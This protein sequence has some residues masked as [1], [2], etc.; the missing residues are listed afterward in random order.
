MGPVNALQPLR[1][2]L[3][4][5]TLPMFAATL[6]APPAPAQPADFDFGDGRH[7]SFTV[8]AGETTI[9]DLWAQV[10]TAS[11]LLAYDPEHGDQVPQL[12]NLTISSGGT[13]TV[14]PYTGNASGA[15]DPTQGGVLRLKV[16]GTL[17]IQ[18]GGA[19]SATGRGYR[20]GTLEGGSPGFIGQQGDSWGN[21]GAI[22][23]AANRG[24]GGGGFGEINGNAN[25][26]SGGGGGH[27]EAGA[28][29]A[30]GQGTQTGGLGGEAFDTVA[31]AAGQGFRDTYLFP[32]FGSGGGRGGQTSNFA[33]IGAYGG[34]GGGVIII[35]AERIVNNGTISADG[36]VGGSDLSGGGGGAGGSILIQTLSESNGTVTVAG[37]AGGVGTV[38]GNVG[39][40]GASGI[41]LW[42]G[43][44]AL[45]TEVVGEGVI[46]LTPAGGRYDDNTV[47]SAEAI[48]DE[49]WMFAGWSGDLSGTDNPD[50]VTMTGDRSI[51]AT[52]VELP[53]LT[54]EPEQRDVSPFGGDL[55][56]GV[57]VAGGTEDIHWTTTVTDGAEFLSIASGA[58]GTND[59]TITVTA[60]P[61]AQENPR[62]G[63][64]LVSSEDVGSD[65]VVITITQGPSTPMLSVTPAEQ[66]ALAEGEELVI[67]VLNTGTG[68]FDWTAAIL[69]GHS[70]A[71]I[72]SAATGTNDGTFVV[73]VAPNL[74]PLQRTIRISVSAPG[75]FGSPEEVTITQLAGVPLLQVSPTSQLIG[76]AAGTASLNVSNGGSGSLGWTAAVIEGA[77]FATITSGSSG[78]N[79]G[80]VTVAFLGN[81][82][83]S[84]RTAKIRVE[85][86]DAANSP[87]DVTIIQTAQEAVLQ[88]SPE[89]QSIGSSAGSASFQVL[90]AGSGT[91]NWTAAV[92][93]GANF[94]SISTGISGTNEGAV[95]VAATA[96]TTGQE[97]SA[98]IRISAPGAANSPTD[99]TLTQAASAPVLR[100]APTEQSV[101]AGGGNISITVE[102]G[103]TGTLNWTASVATGA[104]F[105]SLTPPSN[106]VE[107][108]V[109]QVAVAA[110]ISG[111]SRTGTIR[112]EGTGATSSPQTAT[113]IQLGC[114][115]LDPPANLAASDGTSPDGVDLIWSAVPGA[116]GYEIFR[117]P[118]SDRDHFELLATTTEPR[119]TDTA[120]E[121]PTYELIRE[122]CFNPGEFDIDYT[123]YYYEVRAVNPCGASTSSNRTTGYRGLPRD[124][125]DDGGTD[126]GEGEGEDPT[127]TA[128]KALTEET[129]VGQASRVALLLANDG[130]ID[131]STIVLNVNGVVADL[132]DYFWRPAAEGDDSLGWVVYTGVSDWVDGAPYVLEAGARA[133][134]GTVLSASETFVRDSSDANVALDGVRVV[135]YI[136]E[137]EDTGLFMEGLGVV[138]LATP[139]EV[140]DVPERITIPVPDYARGASLTLYYLESEADGPVWYPADQVRGL[141][142]APPA[143]SEDGA[144]V[145]AWLNHGGTL[146]L[147][148]VPERDTPASIPVNYGT[149]L[150][151]AGT[152]LTLWATGF[153]RREAR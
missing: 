141:L 67:Q 92:V 146:R 101:G 131:P 128:T 91:M 126:G 144:S 139:V 3:R 94:V 123:L 84:N 28:R 69:A 47:V 45:E 59:G 118:E 79:A 117:S 35:E 99:V 17:T 39:G 143:L 50:D 57:T 23:S 1:A 34:N 58:T 4:T 43:R 7:G 55:S 33:N 73:S 113:I 27:R 60:A 42:D 40:T 102:N 125:D 98:T 134:D 53:T 82:S 122:G 32:R 124:D 140:Y 44:Y 5:L 147:G 106:G 31:T 12:E 120:T 90:N 9:Q 138:F 121:K 87:I 46:E 76:S 111:R 52:F 66:T 63:R 51:T 136:P 64:L 72:T 89:S 71:S 21:T 6:I 2:A 110:N 65:P 83:M 54:V 8:P 86:P 16:R 19:I 14:S 15:V 145:E 24:G 18:N 149:V 153:K 49:G 10:R 133:L 56:F 22:S 77:G 37:G 26:G 108:G 150:L 107:D 96:N 100:I 36:A 119:Y 48:A 68:T 152:A 148:Y 105:L 135:P 104:E 25:P 41:L 38:L 81:V 127:D 70:Y 142:A 30:T 11:D 88:V 112:V 114:T 85:T 103:G 97:R 75:A 93:S 115:P 20:G 132:A 80:Q 74:T 61:N 151:L 62:I 78:V 13:L 109:V 116:S 129:P 29:G 137:G 130:G 95:V